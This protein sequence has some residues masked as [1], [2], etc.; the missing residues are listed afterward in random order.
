[1]EHTSEKWRELQLTTRESGQPSDQENSEQVHAIVLKAVKTYQSQLLK[2]AYVFSRDWHIAEDAVQECF[3]A[4]YEYLR[5]GDRVNNLSAWL[6]QT[7]RNFAI[8]Y[9]R[10][11]RSSAE[12][13]Q[14]AAVR[15][16]EEQNAPA[17]SPESFERIM[18]FLQSL[19]DSERIA[20]LLRTTERLPYLEIGEHLGCSPETARTHYRRAMVKIE[21]FCAQ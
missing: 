8:G 6:R 4:L 19:P 16:I 2:H 5:D 15:A 1:M 9:L 3:V 18:V 17:Y 21:E 7:T 11:Q 20:F 14:M 13:E 10:R 12:R